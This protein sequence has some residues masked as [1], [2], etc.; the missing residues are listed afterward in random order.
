MVHY[1][2]V[3]PKLGPSRSAVCFFHIAEMLVSYRLYICYVSNLD[4]D[5][6]WGDG[7]MDNRYSFQPLT[8]ALANKYKDKAALTTFLANMRTPRHFKDYQQ[9]KG[10]L[11]GLPSK[12]HDLWY[13]RSFYEVERLV[14]Y[15]S[16]GADGFLSPQASISEYQEIF[17]DSCGHY[18]SLGHHFGTTS[19]LGVLKK[20]GYERL[21]FFDIDSPLKPAAIRLKSTCPFATTPRNPRVHMRQPRKPQI[22]MTTWDK[23]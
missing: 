7:E 12:Y 10:S 15:G 1:V 17:P 19:A 22:K 18:K 9:N 2:R 21:G 14:V 6:L 23:T 3:W 5:M 16:T 8:P 20:L 13:F 11:L 4:W